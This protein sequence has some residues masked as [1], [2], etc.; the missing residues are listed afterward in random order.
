[1]SVPSAKFNTKDRPE[2]FRVLRGR[3]ND[4]FQ[5]RNISRHGNWDMKLKTVFMLTLYLTPLVLMLTG[6]VSSF[7]P[8]LGMWVIMGFG[9]SGIGLSVMHDANH[10]SYSDS[11]RVNRIMS[12]VIALVGGFHTN[13]QIQHNV[14]HHSYTNV[15]GLDEDIDK[16]IMRFCP[17]QERKK[18]FKYQAF[19]APFLYALMTIYWFIGKDFQQLSRYHKNN[20]LEAQGFTYNTALAS[21]LLVKIVYAA[22]FI[23]L[24]FMMIDLPVW[25]IAIGYMTM[26]FISG[27][28]LALIFQ[29]AHVVEETHFYQAETTGTSLE[30]NWAIHQMQTTSNFANGS[31]FFSWFVGGLNFQIEHHLFPNVCHVHYRNISKIVKETAA[32]FDVPYFQHT[33]FLDALKSHFRFLHHLGTGKYDRDLAARLKAEQPAAE[34]AEVA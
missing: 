32:E 17:T 33:T 8:V 6:I 18:I 19:Y 7:W 9:M 10:G 15:H 21:I 14:L 27:L 30:N 4:H 16:G 3:V 31:T 24:P 25:Q 11:P 5:E 28:I 12:Y 34:L 1:M 29:P 20:L 22:I 13:W 2:F 26:Q 23:V